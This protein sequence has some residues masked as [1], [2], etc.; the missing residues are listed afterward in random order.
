MHIDAFFSKDWFIYLF[1]VY[2][3]TVAVQ[4]VVSLQ[5]VVRNWILGP[6]LDP[7]SPD[8]SVPVAPAQ[9]FIYYYK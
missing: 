5:V 9:R 1:Y 2:E 8:Y 6:L 3:Y 7:F 4:V